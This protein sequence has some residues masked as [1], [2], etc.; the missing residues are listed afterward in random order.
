MRLRR[1]LNDAAALD[2]NLLAA[3]AWQHWFCKR[4]FGPMT[5]LSLDGTVQRKDWLKTV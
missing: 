2:V 1:G 3:K 5:S 4:R